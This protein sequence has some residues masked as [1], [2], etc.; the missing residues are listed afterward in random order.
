MSLHKWT[1]PYN[2]QPDKETNIFG[3][4][5]T[6]F[7]PACR[8]AHKVDNEPWLWGLQRERQSQGLQRELDNSLSSPLAKPLR[9]G[10]TGS[11]DFI[12]VL[13]ETRASFGYL[14]RK[15]SSSEDLTRGG[16]VDAPALLWELV[17]QLGFRF[18]PHPS[19]EDDFTEQNEC[20][21][22]KEGC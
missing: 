15:G 13:L 11:Q 12:F 18:L 10:C 4:L 2:Q 8:W 7:L 3:T 5:E 17:K 20:A 1:Q 6:Q 9:C 16:S 19:S 14:G 22:G 21:G